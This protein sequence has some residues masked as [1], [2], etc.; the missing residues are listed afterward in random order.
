MKK[1]LIIFLVLGGLTLFFYS[2]TFAPVL[3][4][5]D[6]YWF[7]ILIIFITGFFLSAS[8]YP[9]FFF[10]NLKSKN[11]EAI[12]QTIEKSLLAEEALSTPD[13]FLLGQNYKLENSEIETAILKVYSK[14]MLE[15]GQNEKTNLLKKTI[16][17]LKLNEPFA[18]LPESIR[19]HL[20]QV[21]TNTNGEKENLRLLASSITDFIIKAERLNKRERTKSTYGLILGIIGLILTFYFSLKGK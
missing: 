1:V 9:E 17:Q 15:N 3:N 12:S 10:E 20:L 5:F 6:Q 18:N 16:E 2:L 11:L 19:I 14:R 4:F 7:F 8:L 13:L 21:T